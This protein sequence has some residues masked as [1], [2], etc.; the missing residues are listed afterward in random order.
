MRESKIETYFNKRIAELGWLSV[1]IKFL[2]RR[3]CPD[4]L[5]LAPPFS[6]FLAELKRTGKKPTRAQARA[7]RSLEQFGARVFAPN[8]IEAVD[9]TIVQMLKT[10]ALRKL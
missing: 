7:H 6:Y 10:L 8:S 2:G 4:R 1:K 3:N 5:V 9:A